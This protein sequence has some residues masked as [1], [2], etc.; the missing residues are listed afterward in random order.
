MQSI[1][2]QLR[3]KTV[4]KAISCIEAGSELQTPQFILVSITYEV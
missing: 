2:L 3:N 4:T 1:E